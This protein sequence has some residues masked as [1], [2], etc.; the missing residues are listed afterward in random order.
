MLF[1]IVSVACAIV[2]VQELLRSIHQ[3][4]PLGRITGEKAERHTA[5]HRHKFA[6]P[7]RVQ[8]IFKQLQRRPVDGSVFVEPFGVN[9][10]KVNDLLCA[11]TEWLV[12]KAV[13][14]HEQCLSRQNPD[15]WGGLVLTA[16]EAQQIA[17]V[18]VGQ[19]AMKLKFLSMYKKIRDMGRNAH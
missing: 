18:A 7:Q 6:N 8:Q 11:V 5:Q 1:C 12:D 15:H 19:T 10:D 3:E 2:Y 16:K 17:T 14:Q 9:L 4:L 13:L